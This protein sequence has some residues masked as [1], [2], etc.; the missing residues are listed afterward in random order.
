MA[1]YLNNDVFL[2]LLEETANAENRIA[3]NA[4]YMLN[5]LRTIRERVTDEMPDI[6]HKSKSMKK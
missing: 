2:K 1:D 6:I 4:E 5:R 3:R